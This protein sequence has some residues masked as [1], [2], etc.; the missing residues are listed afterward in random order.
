MHNVVNRGRTLLHSKQYNWKRF[1]FSQVSCVVAPKA[2]RNYHVFVQDRIRGRMDAIAKNVMENV[3]ASPTLSQLLDAVRE[4]FFNIE[5][6]M[7]EDEDQYDYHNF[8][9]HFV[10]EWKKGNMMTLA[11]LFKCIARRLRIRADIVELYGRPFIRVPLVDC[12][13]NVHHGRQLE[14]QDFAE[15][16]PLPRNNALQGPL[17]N[18]FVY[19][20]DSQTSV[21]VSEQS[22]GGIMFDFFYAIRDGERKRAMILNDS[23]TSFHMAAWDVVCSLLVVGRAEWPTLLMNCYRRLYDTWLLPP[24]PISSE[25]GD[26]NA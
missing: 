6:F 25:L 1:L 10:L 11:I 8:L 5:G 14:R 15:H 19:Q 3:P 12:Y 9:L 20:H 13:I 17:R 26:D 18:E 23:P 21:V 16:Y 22:I 24:R 2:Y 4:V 7:A